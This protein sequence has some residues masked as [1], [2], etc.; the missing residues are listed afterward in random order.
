M[1]RCT[2]SGNK[3]LLHTNFRVLISLFGDLHENITPTKISTYTV[4]SHLQS[5]YGVLISQYIKR[6]GGTHHS[7]RISFPQ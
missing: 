7:L 2:V 3:Y 5:V 1:I 4:V 6:E